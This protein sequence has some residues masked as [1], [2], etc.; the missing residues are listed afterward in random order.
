MSRR[1]RGGNTVGDRTLECYKQVL[2]SMVNFLGASGTLLRQRIEAGQFAS[3]VDCEV[4][5]VQCIPE[6]EIK[7]SECSKSDSA[8]PEE[9][10]KA[11]PKECA[12]VKGLSNAAAKAPSDQNTSPN[13]DIDT[14]TSNVQEGNVDGSDEPKPDIVNDD[15]TP[16]VKIGDDQLMKSP[17]GNEGIVCICAQVRKIKGTSNVASPSSTDAQGR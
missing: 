10:A 17:D 14:S 7:C 4:E 3:S 6:E 16:P 5:C 12:A 8:N 1:R 9:N 2:D 11:A 13:T 15:K